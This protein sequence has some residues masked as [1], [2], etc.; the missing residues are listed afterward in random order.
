MGTNETTC[1]Y[2][3]EITQKKVLTTPNIQFKGSGFY[4]TDYKKKTTKGE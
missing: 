4:E 3:G 1:P 2:C